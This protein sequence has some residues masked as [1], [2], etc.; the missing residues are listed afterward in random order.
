MIGIRAVATATLMM[1]APALASA[2]SA[3]TVALRTVEV[4]VASEPG[5]ILAGTLHLPA[6]VKSPPPVAVLL[7]GH[8]KN[9]RHGFGE[10]IKRLLADGIAAFAFDKRGVEQS[11]G[12]HTEDLTR[13]TVDGQA[14]V[15]AL[16]RRSDVDGRRIL[17]I[18]HSQGGTIAP[19]IAAADPQI[20][21][22]ALLAGSVGDGLPYLS[23]AIRDQL[24]NRGMPVP[25]ADAIVAA[26]TELLQARVERR[27]EATITPLRN[28]LVARF[29]AAGLPRP[30]AEGALA[31]IDVP[32]AWNID[33]LRS[34]SDLAAVR[35]PVLAV[36]GG[37]DPMVIARSEAPAARTALANNRQAQVV[38]LDGLSHWFQEGAV[39][40]DAEEFAKLGPNAGSPRLVALVGDWVRDVVRRP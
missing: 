40:G 2:G 8:G 14:V 1:A 38:V 5:V 29:E 26:A 12:T 9:G 4:K 31:M 13:L 23:R 37:K 10:I 22:I 19:A 28:A 30:Q 18:G 27:D 36:F 7:Q 16:R 3:T 39:T 6:G 11:T 34:A 25:A 33:K 20:A 17:L 21:G 32:E 15:A 35:A 24:L